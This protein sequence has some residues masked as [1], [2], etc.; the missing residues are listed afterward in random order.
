VFLIEFTSG[1][2]W[3]EEFPK[4]SKEHD[5]GDVGRYPSQNVAVSTPEIRVKPVP[6]PFFQMYSPRPPI[7]LAV[8]T[9]L[10]GS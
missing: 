7:G 3:A 5:L 9:M 10:V 1:Q 2:P 4:K 6:K 8:M